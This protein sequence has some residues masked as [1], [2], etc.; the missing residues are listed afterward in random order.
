MLTVVDVANTTYINDSIF[1]GVVRS[2]GGQ[3]VHTTRNG[4]CVPTLHERRKPAVHK[5]HRGA[6]RG[7]AVLPQG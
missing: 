1:C 2:D 5:F 4:K 3:V 7:R 6:T